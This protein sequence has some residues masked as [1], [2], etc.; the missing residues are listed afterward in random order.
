MP[1]AD[2]FARFGLFVARDF[3]ERD[4]CARILSEARSIA[5]RPARVYSGCE[6][7]RRRVRVDPT[8]RQASTMTVPKGDR[9]TVAERLTALKPSLESHFGL[10][11]TGFEEPMLLRYRQGD[12]F[13]P[14]QDRNLDPNGPLDLNTRLVSLVVFLNVRCS[15][16][17]RQNLGWF[18]L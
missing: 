17:S 16:M 5:W 3:L 13:A 12:F 10:R 8:V 9:A 11:L 2:F 18:K 15:P 6:R 4:L 7:R 14:H 1:P